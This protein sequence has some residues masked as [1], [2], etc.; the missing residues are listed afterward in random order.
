MGV[1]IRWAQVGRQHVADPIVLLS[2]RRSGSNGSGLLQAAALDVVTQPGWQTHLRAL[3]KQLR[4]RRDLL[5]GAISTHVPSATVWA[6]PPGGLNLWVRLPD[7]VDLDR[8]TK[9][10]EARGLVLAGGDEWFPA[11]P[12]GRYLRL[13]FAGPVPAAYKQAA[14]LLDES[15]RAQQ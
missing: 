12:T 10:A 4:A 14:T 15:L 5:V 13:N 7:A 1:G 9:D 8:L 3:R 6:V 2:A 11:E